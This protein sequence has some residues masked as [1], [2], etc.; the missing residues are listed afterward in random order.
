GD[1]LR[2][3]ERGV[4]RGAVPHH[5]GRRRRQARGE[6][7]WWHA[8]WHARWHGRDGRLLVVRR[9]PSGR[10]PEMGRPPG[11]P[12]SRPGTARRARISRYSVWSAAWVT[13]RRAGRGAQR[14]AVAE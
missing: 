14:G 8:R 3:A 5:R 13:P 12:F 4:D 10:I 2:A 11:R 6:G 1:A 7:R 9:S